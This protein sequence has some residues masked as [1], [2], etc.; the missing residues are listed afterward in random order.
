[1]LSMLKKYTDQFINTV[2]DGLN[3][4]TKQQF[5]KFED[6]AE[7]TNDDLEGYRAL[8]EAFTAYCELAEEYA[9][10]TIEIIDKLDKIQNELKDI[11]GRLDMIEARAE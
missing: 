4:M 2:S 6:I 9:D 10:H 5:N 8:N 11:N 3:L 7:I 1:M